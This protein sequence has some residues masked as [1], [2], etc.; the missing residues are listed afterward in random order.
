M[1]TS[2]F[3]FRFLIVSTCLFVRLSSVY[4]CSIG[5]SFHLPWAYENYSHFEKAR[6]ITVYLCVEIIYIFGRA[7]KDHYWLERWN[8]LFLVKSPLSQLSKSYLSPSFTCQSTSPSACL[9]SS[10]PLYLSTSTGVS[11]SCIQ[12]YQ[13]STLSHITILHILHTCLSSYLSLCRSSR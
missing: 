1:R 7:A 11:S 9:S 10:P 2:V 8:H 6:K 5:R 3:V 4:P 13:I 12:S